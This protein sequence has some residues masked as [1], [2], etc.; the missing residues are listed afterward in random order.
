MAELVIAPQRITILLEE[1]GRLRKYRRVPQVC[2][3]VQLAPL[4]ASYRTTIGLLLLIQ[5]VL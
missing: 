2:E 4:T 3:L 1:A 5:G